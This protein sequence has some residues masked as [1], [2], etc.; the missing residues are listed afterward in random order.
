MHKIHFRPGLHLDHAGGAYDAPQPS[1]MVRRTPPYVS[2]C[3]KPLAS[4]SRHIWN[5]V[6]I[7]PHENV[8]P[9]PAMAL[10]GPDGQLATLLNW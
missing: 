4:R 3:L 1:W 8:F 2:S 10:D 6:V 5:E 9:G 7:G